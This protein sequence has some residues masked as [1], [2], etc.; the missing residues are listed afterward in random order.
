MNML[1]TLLRVVHIVARVFWV[2]VSFF[3]DTGILEPTVQAIGAEGQKVMQHLTSQTRFTEMAQAA[4]TLTLLSGWIMY[5]NQFRFR[6]WIDYAPTWGLPEPGWLG[7]VPIRIAPPWRIRQAVDI[8]GLLVLS[9]LAN[10]GQEPLA[11]STAQPTGRYRPGPLLVPEYP[12]PR[13]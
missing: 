13:S 8:S 5:W 12:S 1:M 7:A 4:A 9:L 11:R 10:D 2:V 6:T 3:F